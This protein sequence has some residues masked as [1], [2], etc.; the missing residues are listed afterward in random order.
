[1][2]LRSW[3]TDEEEE[4]VKQSLLEFVARVSSG[5]C[6]QGEA[7]VLLDVSRLLLAHKRLCES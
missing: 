4:S 6:V 2:A 1:M 5:K 3:L 7:S